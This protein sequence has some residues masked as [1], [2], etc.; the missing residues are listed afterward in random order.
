MANLMQRVNRMRGEETLQVARPR[1][2]AEE[3]RHEQP[4]SKTPM[5]TCTFVLEG[6]VDANTKLEQYGAIHRALPGLLVGTGRTKPALMWT[7]VPADAMDEFDDLG[8]DDAVPKVDDIQGA[9]R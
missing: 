9:G 5:E 3:P 1:P 2:A 8:P 6:R 4:R 7:K